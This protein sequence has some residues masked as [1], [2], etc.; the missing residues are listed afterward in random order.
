MKINYSPM[1]QDYKFLGAKVL[2]MTVFFLLIIYIVLTIIFQI[3]FDLS[4][5]D[6]YRIGCGMNAEHYSD[7]Y[8]K[9]YFKN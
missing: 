6:L 3:F 5:V 1:Y 9:E 2:L 8:P 7:C 4:I